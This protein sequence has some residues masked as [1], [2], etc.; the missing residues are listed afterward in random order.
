MRKL[1]KIAWG[2]VSPRAYYVLM[3]IFMEVLMHGDKRIQA[4]IVFMC[5]LVYAVLD[6]P[7]TIE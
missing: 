6:G 7:E 3:G 2:R 5:T 1:A 4:T